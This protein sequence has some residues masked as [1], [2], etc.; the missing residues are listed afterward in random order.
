LRNPAIG[1]P[2]ELFSMVG[3]YFPF[4][5]QMVTSRFGS[6]AGYLE[7]V[8]GAARKL[9]AERYLLER[10][11]GKIEELARREWDFVMK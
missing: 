10:D 8:R 3:S 7:K 11:L 4:A 2:E 9:I 5:K 1:S 6:Q